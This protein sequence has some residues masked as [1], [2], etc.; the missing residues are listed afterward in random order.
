MFLGFILTT[1]NRSLGQ[2]WWQMPVIP[3]PEMVGLGE[4]RAQGQED[5]AEFQVS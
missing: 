3:A 5:Y 1:E 2:Q 4:G